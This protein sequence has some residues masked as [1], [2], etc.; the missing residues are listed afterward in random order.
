MVL[1]PALGPDYSHSIRTIKQML[2]GQPGHPKIKT[3]VVDVR[4][5]ADLHVRAMPA[6]LYFADLK[7]MSIRIEL[8]KL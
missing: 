2:D 4:D 8:M 1:G 6:G 5:V 7:R 3:C